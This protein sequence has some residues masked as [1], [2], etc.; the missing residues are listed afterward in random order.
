MN[1][2]ERHS[3]ILHL[4]QQ[5]GKIEV[6]YLSDY[7][8]ISQLTIRKDLN[9]LNDRG[10]L[11]RCYGG[12]KS[13][14]ST[15]LPINERQKRYLIQKKQIGKLASELVR[16]GDSIFIDGGTTTEQLVE[17]LVHL[18]GL[19]VITNSINIVN[20]LM[21][22][23]NI[24]IYVP[25][26]KIDVRGASI[27]GSLAENALEKYNARIA[28]IGVDGITR[29][30]GLLNN[31]FEA[32]SLSQILLKNTQTKVLMV[33]SSKFDAIGSVKLCD[34]KDLDVIITDRNIPEEYVK[35][36]KE[37]GIQLMIT[38]N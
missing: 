10:Q 15:E 14:L 33:D 29:N 12:A 37:L 34:L 8:Q 36:C 31:S 19:V 18:N 23:G 17:N 5:Y 6:S 9:E 11:Q 30:Q 27:V 35:L 21:N 1:K 24:N 16:D 7:F 22:L 28:F 13:L 2:K 25:E 20:R 32:N 3:T 4:L 26:G 38:E